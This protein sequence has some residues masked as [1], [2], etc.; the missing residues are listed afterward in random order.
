M[1]SDRSRPDAISGDLSNHESA[2]SDI[3]KRNE[4]VDDGSRSRQMTD[5]ITLSIDGVEVT[6]APGTNVLQ[7][8]MDAGLY[9]PYL[10][11]YPG[12]KAF[13]ACR[14]CVV[15]V[16]G[17]PG[18]PA[19]CTTPATDGMA[20]RTDTPEIVSLRRGIM[21][22]LISEHPHGCLNCHRIDLCGPSDICLR[23]VSVN[24]RCV[25]CPKNER[26]ELK[27]TVRYLELE[28]DT[29]L[30]YNNRH[31]PLQVEDPFWEMDLN[32]CIVC[33]R[34]VRVCEEIRGDDALTFTD[35][36]GRSL[37]GT[38]HGTSLLESGCEFCGAC[39]DACPTGALVERDHKWDKAV[40]TVTSICPHCPVGCQMTLEVDKR[41]RLIRAT[42]DM[43]APANRGQ[44]CYKG[45]F[46]LEFVNRRERLRK[47]LIRVNGSLEES[48]LV[49]TLDFVSKR[50][51]DY[52]GDQFAL[53]ASP[54]GT[55]EDN[56]IAQ[57]FAR[58]VMGT[59]NV[60]V[61]SNVR[62]ELLPPLGEMLGYQAGTNPIWDL[63]AA[64]CFL[65]VSS[66]VTEEQTVAAVP[67][68][69]MVKK[70]ASLI[71]IDPRE[72]E[73]TRYANIW[74]RPVP[75]SE[76]ALIG[77]MLRVIFDESLDDHEYLADRCENVEELRNSLWAFDLIRVSELTGVPQDQV[78]AAAR[79]FAR[80]APC[81][82]LYGLETVPPQL[83]A[84]CVRGLVNLS[85][86]TGNI[87][88]PS[89]GLYPLYPGT[90]E[91]GSKDVGC[92]P[93]FL[94]G[95]QPVSDDEAR[96]LVGQ[97]WGAE[98][99]STEGLGIREI[100]P[101]IREGKLK[102][103]LLIG[104]SPNFDN[105]ELG[106]FTEALKGL[107][108]LV[109]QDN[110]ASELTEI[111]DA[112]LPS[113]TFAEKDGT[114]T[115]MERRVQLLRPALGPKG[116][117]EADWRLISQIARR[118]GAEGFEHDDSESVF[119]EATGL[120]EVYGGLSHQ[121]LRSGGL[122]WPCP[123]AD[124]EDTPVL[125]TPDGDGRKAS[126][127]SMTMPETP[128]SRDLEYP[129]LLARGRLLHQSDRT[130][131]IGKNGKRNVIQREELLELHEDDARNLGISEGEWVEVVSSRDRVRGVAR[132]TSPQ[133]GLVS[134][135]A[136]FGQ[137][138]TELDRSE[139]PDPM[140]KVEGL[141]LVPV[142]VERVLE[143]AAD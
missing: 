45:K 50:L 92:V 60:D 10:C 119:D 89:A 30:T 143:A 88:K 101:A 26:C 138:A 140:L 49:E 125:Y 111:A 108:F 25:T 135:T 16:E 77:G 132:L 78:Q 7:A 86:S 56:Y 120:V 1:S 28:L 90:N 127:V 29:P 39:I 11:Y 20:V 99:P 73:L 93:D 59:N 65:V 126:V 41:N 18:S 22:L 63:E 42:P 113:A 71:V 53:I 117:E 107:D 44:V 58:T 68:K 130:M 19:S 128:E 94:A 85:L 48:T 96:R 66:N 17:G 69:K 36:A 40:E 139:A 6:T 137:L 33:G 123:A 142:R 31:L 62:P 76:T 52:T 95:Y 116:D 4:H 21:D 141:P 55:N 24:D 103:L 118:M 121:R 34:C 72:T 79:L 106:D 87:G 100:A 112:V 129:L 80:S 35:R 91:Q 14:M 75:G 47:P 43:Q 110:F 122:Q 70:G 27:D 3:E 13:G 8:A 2:E 23:H 37:I 54:R 9:I 131:E 104:D 82:V 12:T 114:Y 51:A 57:K 38:S 97:A 124:T 102:S 84:D 133:A 105:G 115:N 64:K 67:I 81:A 61:S 109:V 136:L 15:D 46:G 98:I 74:L 134:T 32:L 83:R 5:E